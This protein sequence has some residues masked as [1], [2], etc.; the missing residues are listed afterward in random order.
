MSILTWTKAFKNDSRM[1]AILIINKYPD[2]EIKLL[3]LSL[4]ITN[5]KVILLTVLVLTLTSF[6]VLSQKLTVTGVLP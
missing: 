2:D 4:N 5:G 6:I 3:L 1:F